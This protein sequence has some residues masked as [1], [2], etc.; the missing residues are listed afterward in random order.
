MSWATDRAAAAVFRT[1]AAAGE[2]G[3]LRQAT[4][5]TYDP[6]TRTTTGTLPSDTQILLVPGEWTNMRSADGATKRVRRLLLAPP[7]FTIT[8]GMVVLDAAAVAYTIESV[9]S[10]RYRGVEV[11]LQVLASGGAP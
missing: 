3:A 4:A 7:S 5:Q 6:A 10:V 8:A 1:L 9:A 2:V 11:A